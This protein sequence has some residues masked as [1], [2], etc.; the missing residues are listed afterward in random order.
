MLVLKLKILNSFLERMMGCYLMILFCIIIL[1]DCQQ[2]DE[3]VECQNK[4]LTQYQLDKMNLN[5]QEKLV[6]QFFIS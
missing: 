1:I 6:N 3:I 5:D 2:I 4:D